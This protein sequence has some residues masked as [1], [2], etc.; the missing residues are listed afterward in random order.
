M[1][2]PIAENA[3]VAWPLDRL[4]APNGE[5]VGYVMPYANTRTTTPSASGC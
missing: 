4:L 3:A 2:D 1:L 5:C